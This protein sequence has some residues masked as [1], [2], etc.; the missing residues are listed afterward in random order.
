MTYSRA[1]VRYAGCVFLILHDFDRPSVPGEA[2]PFH[3]QLQGV[4]LSLVR[5][6]SSEAHERQ[7]RHRLLRKVVEGKANKMTQ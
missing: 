7:S 6:S 4:A 3:I 5:Q 1:S 2:F